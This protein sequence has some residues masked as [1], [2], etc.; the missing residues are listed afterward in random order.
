MAGMVS[1][2]TGLELQDTSRTYSG[3]LDLD[4][5]Y[6]VLEHIPAMCRQLKTFNRN[7]TQPIQ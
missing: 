3:G 7:H 5:E 4:L 1:P 6:A 2:M